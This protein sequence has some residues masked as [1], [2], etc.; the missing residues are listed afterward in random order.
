[1]HVL[2]SHIITTTGYSVNHFLII[3]EKRQHFPNALISP[4]NSC[5]RGKFPTP[6]WE[7]LRGGGGGLAVLL[8]SCY[9]MEIFRPYAMEI[10]NGNI[11][12]A[13]FPFHTI[14]SV[15]KTLLN[16]SQLSFFLVASNNSAANKSVLVAVM[17]TRE[18]QFIL[19]LPGGYRYASTV[20]TTTYLPAQ[21]TEA[22]V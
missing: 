11:P 4:R 18:T 8:Q 22:D 19:D 12:T 10:F 3:F 2:F 5:P 7:P 13:A 17:S 15:Q 9:S 21:V 16:Y 14:L 6:G 1:M 20:N